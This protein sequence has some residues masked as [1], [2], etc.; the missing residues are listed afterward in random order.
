MKVSK[1]EKFNIF[2]ISVA[3]LFLLFAIHLS[4]GKIRNEVEAMTVSEKPQ[5]ET[6]MSVIRY[7]LSKTMCMDNVK[8]LVKENGSI[9]VDLKSNDILKKNLRQYENRK[10]LAFKEYTKYA[11]EFFKSEKYF[12]GKNGIDFEVKP[13]K[14][15]DD[16]GVT[17]YKIYLAFSNGKNKDYNLKI[18]EE[19][20]YKTSKD[21]VIY[22]VK[23]I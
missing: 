14:T 4:N 3:I 22:K 20:L 11:K 12:W 1:K 6:Q 9:L 8:E 5:Y 21:M 15:K 19:D 7:E 16:S 10:D 18:N 23:D 13:I 17:K 2:R